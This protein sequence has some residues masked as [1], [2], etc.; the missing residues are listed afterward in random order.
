MIINHVI[1]HLLRER[2]YLDH[3]YFNE[4][5]IEIQVT[6]GFHKPATLLDVLKVWEILCWNHI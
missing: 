4:N 6:Y 3:P 1:F 5:Y 2:P